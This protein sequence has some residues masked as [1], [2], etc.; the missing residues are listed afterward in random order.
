MEA[1]NDSCRICDRVA[2]WRGG[3]SPYFIHEFEHS[4]FVVGDHRFHKGYCLLLLKDHVREL[5][6]LAPPVQSAL[7]RELMTAGEALVSVFKPWKMNYSCYGNADPHVH[8]HLF[9][10][11][12]DDPER[13]SHPWLHSPEFK[14][15]LVDEAT[16]REYSERIRAGL[17][18]FLPPLYKT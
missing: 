1:M 16:A 4:I 7:F 10:R 18:A 2:L 15:H 8:W 17:P 5:H 6:D 11:Y 12:A 14:E 9:P 3:R 13:E